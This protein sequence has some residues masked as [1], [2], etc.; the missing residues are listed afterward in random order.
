MF[1]PEIVEKDAFTV[2]GM[3]AHFISALSPDTNNLQ[4][5]PPLWDRFVDRIDEIRNRSDEA[6]YGLVIT[7]PERERSHPDEL[8]YV[9][10]C[11]VGS[12][13][14]LPGGMV[15]HE[16]P[17]STFAVI[18][19]R[20]IAGDDSLRDGRLAAQLQLPLESDRGRALRPSLLHRVASRFRDGDMDGY[21]PRRRLTGRSLYPLDDC[22]LAWESSVL[23]TSERASGLPFVWL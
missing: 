12:V 7:Q 18:T 8:L 6:C 16:I 10:G 21:S 11:M 14:S 22:G 17:T 9:A 2:V 3:E 5:I 15:T 19:H 23:A 4:V 1:E 13:A 20:R